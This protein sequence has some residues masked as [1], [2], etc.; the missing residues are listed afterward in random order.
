MLKETKPHQGICWVTE[1]SMKQTFDSSWRDK[2]RAVL[3]FCEGYIQHGNHNPA[4]I[5]TECCKQKEKKESSEHD[6]LTLYYALLV[7]AFETKNSS[8]ISVLTIVGA[9]DSSLGEA[10]LK[11]FSINFTILT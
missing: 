11:L 10:P 4:G 9:T 3:C 8:T 7:Q 5:Q 6:P 1:T 2:D